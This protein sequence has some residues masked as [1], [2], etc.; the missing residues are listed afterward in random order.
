MGSPFLSWFR[1]N[2]APT[3]NKDSLNGS[4]SDVR[5]SLAPNSFLQIRTSSI[6]STVLSGLAKACL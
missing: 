5:K 1:L 2:K 3:S 4:F 6:K